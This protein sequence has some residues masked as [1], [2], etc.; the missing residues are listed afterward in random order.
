MDSLDAISPID[1]RYRKETEAL[2]AY[3][4]ENALIRYPF[5]LSRLAI[6]NFRAAS[7]WLIERVNSDF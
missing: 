7:K 4:S 6:I 5:I 1:G 3:F 2:A